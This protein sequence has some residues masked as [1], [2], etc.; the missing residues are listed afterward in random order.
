M[1]SSIFKLPFTHGI[2]SEVQIVNLK[3]RWID[4]EKMISIMG[5]IVHDVADGLRMSS[6]K[7]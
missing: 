6:L 4:G 2:E 1:S 5:K 7:E 3:G